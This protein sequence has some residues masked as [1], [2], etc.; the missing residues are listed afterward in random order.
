MNTIY[1]NYV[2]ALFTRSEGEEGRWRE[3][4]SKRIMRNSKQ[5]I[6]S[7]RNRNRSR[8]R[9]QRRSRNES[10][11]KGGANWLS[12]MMKCNLRVCVCV[13]LSCYGANERVCCGGERDRDRFART[14]RMECCELEMRQTK[15]RGGERKRGSGTLLKSGQTK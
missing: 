15:R 10:R 14:I 8:R 12:K 6:Y 11:R 13:C 1:A 4:G 9:S 3:R 2:D 5:N 7:K